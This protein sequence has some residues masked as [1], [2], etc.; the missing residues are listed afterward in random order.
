MKLGLQLPQRAAAVKAADLTAFA[1]AAEQ[2]G[3][4]SLWA[5]E[6]VLFPLQP[7]DGMYG[8]PGLPWDPYYQDCADPLTV[9]GMAAAVTERVRLGTALL[10]A[11]L[12]HTL[13]LARALATLDVATGGGR[14]VAGLGGGWST[15]E[16][17]AIGADFTARGRSMDETAEALRTL[18]G[19]NPVTYR[20]SAISIDHA[21]VNPKPA[22]PIPLVFGGSSPAAFR[23]IAA[24][25]DGWFPVGIT[26]EP[27]AAAWRR[28]REVT[29]AA[30]R[31]PDQLLLLPVAIVHLSDRPAAADRMPFQGSLDQVLDDLAGTAKAGAHEVILSLDRTPGDPVAT[32][33]AALAERAAALHGAARSAGLLD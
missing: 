4:A 30:G 20:D 31:D 33:P 18:W 9:L 10:V 12:H 13:Q 26:G 16:Y 21:L 6:R 1:R 23:R 32:D 5:Y 19:P 11:P 8:V 17:R 2:A 7:A 25:G 14:V 15:D 29:E 22:G 27:L 28:L 3:Y 24:H